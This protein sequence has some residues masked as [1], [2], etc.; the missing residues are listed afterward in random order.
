MALIAAAWL[1]VPSLPDA[2]RTAFLI[3]VTTAA[4]LVM[5][6]AVF[7]C[8]LTYQSSNILMARVRDIYRTDLR[9]NWTSV[10]GGAFLAAIVPVLALLAPPAGHHVAILVGVY[11]AG[12]VTARMF[13]ALRWLIYTLFAQELDDAH[14][15]VK[16]P[17]LPSEGARRG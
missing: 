14:P 11:A 13:R 10:I 15:P 8:A 2:D 4:G 5:A 1:L 16:L 3:G 7:A 6:A 12:I 9:R 17:A